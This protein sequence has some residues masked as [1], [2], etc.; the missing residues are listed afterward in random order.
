MTIIY[1]IPIIFSNKLY[2]LSSFYKAYKNILTIRT[3]KD[4]YLIAM[5]LVSGRIYKNDISDIIG[6]INESKKS[7]NPISYDMVDKTIN[8]LYGGWELLNKNIIA[9]LNKILESKNLD[10]IYNKTINE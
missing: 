9:T 6:I 8:D 4:E 1:T 2:E 7:T 10:E 3:I 5:K